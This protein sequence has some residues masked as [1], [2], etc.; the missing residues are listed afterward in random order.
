MR[1]RRCCTKKAFLAIVA[2]SLTL[3]FRFAPTTDAFHASPKIA[4]DTTTT[5]TTTTTRSHRGSILGFRRGSGFTSTTSLFSA[6]PDDTSSD[7]KITNLKKKLAQDLKLK[8]KYAGGKEL[9]DLRTDLEGLR[10]NLVWAEA[11]KDEGKVRDLKEAIRQSENRDPDLVFKRTLKMMDELRK[12]SSSSAAAS[13][14]KQANNTEEYNRLMER[15]GREAKAARACMPRFQLAGLWVGNYGGEDGHQVVNITYS[16]D[17]LTA[18]KVTGD[19][20]VPRGIVTF[21]ADMSVRNITTG[22]AHELPPIELTQEAAK[23]WGMDKLER[24]PGKGQIAKEG[25]EDSKMVDGQLIFYGNHFSFV[26]TLTKQHVFFGRPSD[27]VV[28]KL[29]RDTVSKEDELEN[30]KVYLNRCF[31]LDEDS[32]SSIKMKESSSSP[33]SPA[34]GGKNKI[35]SKRRRKRGFRRI[36]NTKDLKKIEAKSL[37]P[38]SSALVHK[39][40]D[41]NRWRACIDVVLG[42]K[43]KFEE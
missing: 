26:W 35:N 32:L 27:N 16:G 28:L 11:L 38:T 33:S 29:M 40:W 30:K 10:A 34:S 39:F 7:D 13:S 20:N 14:N 18:R 22:E 25:Y 31:K 24:F 6:K 2:A 42:D 37:D 17:T 9:R 8:E 41:I 1:R 19:K 43:T 3:V 5:T 15:L 21:E 36:A 4:V 23:K 12:A